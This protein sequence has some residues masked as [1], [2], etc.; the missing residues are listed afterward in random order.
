MAHKDIHMVDQKAFNMDM[1][2]NATS[3]QQY[4]KS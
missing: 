4:I 1:N 3:E 2:T